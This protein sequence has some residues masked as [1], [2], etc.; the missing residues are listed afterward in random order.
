MVVMTMPILEMIEV[1]PILR[2]TVPKCSTRMEEITYFVL[3]YSKS[4]RKK[5]IEIFLRLRR[6]LAPIHLYLSSILPVDEA[7]MRKIPDQ[8]P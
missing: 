4:L 3:E 7:T 8:C 1:P 2:P 6:L 5:I